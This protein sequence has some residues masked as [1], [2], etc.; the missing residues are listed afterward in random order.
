MK[1][2]RKLCTP[3][4]LSPRDPA[5]ASTA[6][7]GE[8]EKGLLTVHSLCVS[9]KNRSRYVKA[10]DYLDVKVNSSE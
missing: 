5:P 1:E 4:K 6:P 7:A 8:G 2:T 10:G 9:S 3:V